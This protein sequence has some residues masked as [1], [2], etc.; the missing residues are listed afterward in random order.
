MKLN[1]TNFQHF[2]Y[3]LVEPSPWPILLSFSLLNMAIGAVL[4]MHGFYLGGS[5]LTLGFVLTCFGMTLWFRDVITESTYLG[6]HTKQ[7]KTGLM[8]GVILFIV[9]EVFAFL[10]IF[11]AFFSF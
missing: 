3:H 5:L 2:P 6:H 9:S 1:I 7:V 8:I 4:Y 10:S 11:W